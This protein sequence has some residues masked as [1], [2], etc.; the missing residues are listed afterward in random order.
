[1]QIALSS[2]IYQTEEGDWIDRKVFRVNWNNRASEIT[3]HFIIPN[4]AEKKTNYF[5][6]RHRGAK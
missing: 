2:A 4:E 3:R 6:D 5:L 1:M